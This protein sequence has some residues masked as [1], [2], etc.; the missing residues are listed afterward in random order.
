MHS[1]P[2]PPHSGHRP[3][4]ALH[5]WNSA[6]SKPA[7]HSTLHAQQPADRAMRNAKAME[8]LVEGLKLPAAYV[9]CKLLSLNDLGAF[10]IR[11]TYSEPFEGD[12]A[13]IV[14]FL[15]QGALNSLLGDPLRGDNVRR[16]RSTLM[17]L[18]GI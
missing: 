5:S 11:T 3:P 14:H 12:I 2:F 13:H 1:T 9:A 7:M 6:P 8:D 10:R 16:L 15:R 17:A 18:L 4:Y